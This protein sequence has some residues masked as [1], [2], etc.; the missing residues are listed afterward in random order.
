MKPNTTTVKGEGFDVERKDV[1]TLMYNLTLET[2]LNSL[3]KL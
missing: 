1:K 2:I 3:I